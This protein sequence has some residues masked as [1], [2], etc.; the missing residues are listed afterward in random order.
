MSKLYFRYSTMN[1][2]KSL[3]LLAVA[4]NYKEQG[5]DVL[6]LK[7]S[8]DTRSPKGLIESR[9]GISMPC[10][11]IDKDENLVELFRREDRVINNK[12]EAI[13][14]DEASFLTKEQVKQL[15]YIVDKFDIPCLT[16][17]LKNSYIDGELFEG[18]QALLYYS[19]EVEEIKNVCHCGRKATMN[20]R[21]V[22][23]E[24]VYNG[25]IINCGDTK[26]DNDYYM[27]VCRKHY[28]NPI[29]IYNLK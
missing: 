19:D 3:N 8:L 9:V 27:P 2:A 4:H 11:D 1:S 20:L 14:V 28:Y 25:E 15:A 29:G 23:G 22:N 26:P 24:P 10:I 18:S 7:P 17:G 12:F 16:Y 5:K 13:L 6:L 21:I